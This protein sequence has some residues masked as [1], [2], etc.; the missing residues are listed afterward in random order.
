[1]WCVEPRSDWTPTSCRT[2]VADGCGSGAVSLADMPLADRLADAAIRAGAEA[3]FTR[4][5][6]LAW[7]N[8]GWPM[9][10]WPASHR[11][12][13]GGRRCAARLLSHR[14]LDV[15]PRRSGGREKGH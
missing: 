12:V 11:R 15:G 10:C 3:Y 9:L 5:W 13:I 6:A 2:R 4:S 1:M 8:P 14:G 7:S